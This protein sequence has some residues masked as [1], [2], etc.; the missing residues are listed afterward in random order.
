MQDIA[1]LLAQFGF[2]VVCALAAFYYVKY[3]GDKN[4]EMIESINDRH[5]QE[6]QSIQQIVADNTAAIVSLRA[7]LE[8]KVGDN[9]EGN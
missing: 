1:T 6:M 2:P 8:G 3:T 5:N 9:V 7:W 4:R